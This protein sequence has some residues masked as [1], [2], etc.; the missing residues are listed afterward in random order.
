MSVAEIKRHARAAGRF[1]GTAARHPITTG[2]T[3]GRAA[4]LLLTVRAAVP[5][6]VW[7][8]LAVAALVKCWPLDM[9]LDE[10]LFTLAFALIAWQRPG[11][12]T[13]LWREAEAGKPPRCQCDRPK[14]ARKAAKAAAR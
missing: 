1:A 14:C 5:R 9:G 3:L 6:Y 7:P 11:L 10:A 8:I 2:K 12:V 13:A 4:K